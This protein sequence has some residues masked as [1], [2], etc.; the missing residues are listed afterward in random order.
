M[1]SGSL[2]T[3][4]NPA[5]SISIGL[6]ALIIEGRPLHDDE[7]TTDIADHFQRRQS[8]LNFPSSSL[9]CYRSQ[10]ESPKKLLGNLFKKKI[11]IY[12]TNNKFHLI[13]TKTHLSKNIINK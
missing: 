11:S 5:F 1:H 6:A 12:Y 3:P 13:N 4:D 2:L 7:Y 10:L 8:D 9:K